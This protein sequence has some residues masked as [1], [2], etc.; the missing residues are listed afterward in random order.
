LPESIYSRLAPHLPWLQWLDGAHSKNE[1]ERR[2]IWVWDPAEICVPP[3]WEY[4]QTQSPH[5]AR[6][7][8]GT[9]QRCE[10]PFSYMKQSLRAFK[11]KRNTGYSGWY[12]IAGY[13]LGMSLLS[14]PISQQKKSGMKTG[15]PFWFGRYENILCY[16]PAQKKY[17]LTVHGELEKEKFFS[18]I[19]S[20][21]AQ[22]E[23]KLSGDRE[24]NFFL[25][26]F[27]LFPKEEREHYRKQV[28]RIREE[29][30]QGNVYQVNYT[31]RFQG[32]TDA[33]PQEIFNVLREKS[34][35]PYAALW[36][37]G[38]Y[39]VF[40]LSPELFLTICTTTSLISRNSAA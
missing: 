8:S 13:E 16:D 2:S 22:D 29:I 36:N 31:T 20:S 33:S 32:K 26:P 12:G 6:Q 10:N 38:Q 21:G 18:S 9:V 1:N 11:K 19:D 25:F 7:W 15:N 4:R 14:V 35:V 34:P 23:A 39:F 24:P 27:S 40:S 3:D 5:G 37:T 30:A 28:S 17:F